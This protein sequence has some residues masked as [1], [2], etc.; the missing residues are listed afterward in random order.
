MIYPKY[1]SMCVCIHIWEPYKK[2]V[3]YN[4]LRRSYSIRKC[5][6]YTR[7]AVSLQSE[8]TLSLSCLYFSPP[9]VSPS[10]D[11]TP[12]HCPASSS[13]PHIPPALSPTHF[14]YV[15]WKSDSLFIKIPDSFPHFFKSFIP[16]L[17]PH[18]TMQV[19]DLQSSQ[20]IFI[21][22]I[23][24]PLAFPT[25]EIKENICWSL[26]TVPLTELLKPL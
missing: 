3:N 24:H 11:Q 2:A 23:K 22:S 20:S 16:S 15:F 7:A 9:S 10:D 19:S 25:C 13:T 8:C 21:P 18:V 14:H 5:I 4:Y 17:V 12:A 26:P 1:I 6:C